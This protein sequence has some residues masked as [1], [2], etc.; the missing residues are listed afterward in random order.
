MHR[1]VH[2]PRRRSPAD[3][4]LGPIFISSFTPGY[5]RG[6]ER[7]CKMK[8]DG[9]ADVLD[10]NCSK[11][12]W[13]N[14]PVNVAHPMRWSTISSLRERIQIEIFPS[15]NRETSFRDLLKS[16]SIRCSSSSFFFYIDS[17]DACKILCKN[18]YDFYPNLSIDDVTRW[19][20]IASI[21]RFISTQSENFDKGTTVHNWRKGS[22]VLKRS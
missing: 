22:V 5:E 20:D 9:S 1:R 4:Y 16:R 19:R 11:G 13:H 10:D 17:F 15:I 14:T 18:S 8:R 2:P 6:K 21:P 12:W 7:R 3:W